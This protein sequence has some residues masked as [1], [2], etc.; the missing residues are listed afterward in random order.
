M[1]TRKEV[2]HRAGVSVATVS[3]VLNG[4]KKVTP[5]VEARV[6]QAVQELGYRPNLLARGLSKKETRHVA[7]VVDNMHNPH[8]SDVLFGAQEVASRNGY[9]VSVL[10]V[11]ISRPQDLLDL[12]SRGVDGVMLALV[13]DNAS[14]MELLDPDMPVVHVGDSLRIDQD[15]AMDDMVAHLTELGHT[16]IAYLSGLP[17]RA[18]YHPRFI[19]LVKAL[20]ARGLSIEPDRIVSGKSVACVDEAE[21]FRAMN[22][23]LDR[24]TEFTA[25]YAINDLVAM[26]AIR[27]L[28][29]RGLRVPED[30]SVVGNDWLEV[31]RWVTPTLAT[32]EGY[33][34]EIGNR[35]MNLMIERIAMK[36]HEEHTIIVKYVP[37]ESVGP[38]K[39]SPRG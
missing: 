19:S 18:P 28:K 33:A 11:D 5:E 22:E 23:L 13:A 38:A 27:A 29:Q 15:Q 9:I 2:A 26:G 36:P 3:Y 30:I 37:G 12:T 14:L 1:A 24:R 31:Y 10:S 17:H 16:K 6:R 20:N 21:G 8:I 4:T 7:L 39:K 35:L 25:V 34:V 32:M